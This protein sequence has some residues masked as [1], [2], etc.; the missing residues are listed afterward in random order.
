MLLLATYSEYRVAS[1]ANPWRHIGRYDVR[2][3]I[4][5]FVKSARAEAWFYDIIKIAM[6]RFGR[7]RELESM[8][9]ITGVSYGDL[10]M[11]NLS[12]ELAQAG[13][14]VGCTSFYKNGVHGRNL[15]WDYTWLKRYTIVVD[16]GKFKAVSWPGYIGALTACRKGLSVAV[17]QAPTGVPN[18]KGRPVAM[19]VREFMSGNYK[20]DWFLKNQPIFPAFIHVVT[21][22]SVVY[23]RDE[24][25]EIDA[26]TN[27]H[28]I[29]GESCWDS[30]ERRLKAT[31]SGTVRSILKKTAN[32]LTVQS[33][34]MDNGKVTLL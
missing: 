28:P 27:H 20:P 12:Y 24:R 19:L 22:R 26:I 32:S 6:S 30:S 34:I 23:H 9:K 4:E 29:T 3:L 17:N 1:E 14:L 25:F 18:L 13:S 15:D 33:I 21:D 7:W 31:K 11:A 10:L 8:S 5:R 16:Y 2:G